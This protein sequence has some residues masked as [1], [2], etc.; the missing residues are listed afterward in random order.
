GGDFDIPTSI[1]D[2]AQTVNFDIPFALLT[3]PG[4]W[5][6]WGSPPDTDSSTPRVLWSIGQT[7]ATLTFLDADTFAFELEQNSAATSFTAELFD[8]GVSLG[9]I[10]RNVDANAGARLSA[11][12]TTTGAFDSVVITG[13]DDFAITQVRYALTAQAIPEPA[14]LTMF[15]AAMLGLACR[16]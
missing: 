14:S 10:T 11:A 15:A 13:T 8:G 16:L 1:T 3:V 12:T 7:T 6:A 9:S 2:G 4:T 5:S